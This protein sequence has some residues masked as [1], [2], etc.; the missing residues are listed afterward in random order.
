MKTLE[1][2][3]RFIL[4][5][6]TGLLAQ[7]TSVAAGLFLLPFVIHH[8]G[9]ERVGVF[10]LGRSSLVFLSLL[11]AGMGPAL[12]RFTAQAFASD[13]HEN[14]RQI[15][16]T[17]AV[18]LGS[19]AF[20]T[21][22]LSVALIPTFLK[23]YGLDGAVDLR[24]DT[25]RFLALLSASLTVNMLALVPQGL[26]LGANRYSFD[27][28]VTCMDQILRILFMVASFHF[29]SP[30]L[31]LLGLSIF[32][33]GV[34]RLTLLIVAVNRGVRIQGALSPRNARL[35]M[36]R[37][38]FSFSAWTFAGTIAASIIA[39]GPNL[40]IGKQIGPAAVA[41]LAPVFLIS[42]SMQQL[43]GNLSKPLVPL[44][45]RAR[46]TG[47]DSDLGRMSIV[48]S[49]VISL[50]GLAM[51]LPISV[52]GY[53]WIACW[54]GADLAWTWKMAAV[55]GV[56]TALAQSQFANYFL[57]LGGGDIRP[58]IKSQFLLAVVSCCGLWA[59]IRWFEWGLMSCVLFITGCKCL[60]NIVY[61][62]WAYSR[63]LHYSISSF[64]W[65]VYV[66][67]AGLALMCAGAWQ[68]LIGRH[69]QGATLLDLCFKSASLV[70]LFTLASIF[71][72]T[73]PE[74]RRMMQARVA[75][76]IGFPGASRRTP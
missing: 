37:S 57:A 43:L 15:G 61:L 5:C 46:Q 58:M 70:L 41:L 40:I 62:T 50:V 55:M 38:I 26:L 6:S 33:S 69:W 1:D 7:F 60:R 64:A 24:V 44:G 2:R 19:L 56:G 28:F 54:L 20:L 52:L 36:A 16:G 75:G 12:V 47:R 10:Q 27:N 73:S 51:A 72:F 23:A 31:T 74:Q 25:V 8:L 67:P 4:H 34:I 59:G 14:I 30:S 68:I 76:W 53:D 39:Q 71:T 21:G 35:A 66:L 32:V 18:V 48:V 49:Q 65:S 42:L 45:S 13:N 11:Q 9:Q 29:K 63:S 22:G 3:K 17:A